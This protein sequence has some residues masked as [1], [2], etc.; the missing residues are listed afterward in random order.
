MKQPTIIGTIQK[1]IACT[2]NANFDDE[3]YRRDVLEPARKIRRLATELG[4]GAPSEEQVHEAVGLL[5]GILDAK[6]VDVAE[7]VEHLREFLER[8]DL[9]ARFPDLIA[10]VRAKS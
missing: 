2:P 3:A 1:I 7:R 6:G 8:H 9:E 10:G 4:E 5:L